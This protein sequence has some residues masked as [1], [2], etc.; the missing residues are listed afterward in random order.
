MKVPAPAIATLSIDQIKPWPKNPRKGHAVDK[1]A[2]SIE[3]VGYQAPIIVQK[4]THRILAGHGRLEALRKLGATEIPCIVADVDDARADIYTLADNKLTELAEWDFGRMADLLIEMEGN[5]IDTRLTGFDDE[6][7]RRIAEWTPPNDGVGDPDAVPEPPDEPITQPGDLWILG[8]HRL[9]C[10]DSTDA[11]SVAAL[12]DGSRAI[13]MATDP[14]YGVA[15]DNAERPDRGVA[16]PRVAKPRVANDSITDGPK[17][18]AFLESMLAAAL[19]AMS[20]SAAFYFWH[21]MLTQGTYVAAAAAAAAAGIFIH[22]QIIW[23]KA[24]LL[25]GHGDYH[26][27]HELCFYGWRRGNRPPFYGERNQDTVWEVASI[28]QKE[29]KELNHATPKPVALW[30]RPILNHTKPGEIIY[31]PFAGSGAQVIAAEQHGRR[32]YAIEIEPRYCD[33]IARRWEK[34]TGKKAERIQSAG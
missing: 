18:Q 29:R 15:Y 7:L 21:P 20:E 12:M 30:D 6:E 19:P 33:V 31:E 14:P 17:M 32:C 26:W 27:R 9:L 22:R 16:K 11:E 28:G 1:I 24:S 10:G 4:G 8:N 2:A 23:V 13:L 5:G 3:A 25:L 34:F